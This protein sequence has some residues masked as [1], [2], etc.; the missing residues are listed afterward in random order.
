MVFTVFQGRLLR[1]QL[2]LARAVSHLCTP[3]L[4]S[5]SCALD[6][7]EAAVQDARR[8]PLCVGICMVQTLGGVGWA[9]PLFPVEDSSETHLIRLFRRS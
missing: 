8:D 9:Q 5:S 4:T 1:A 3:V 6:L 7:L 2:L